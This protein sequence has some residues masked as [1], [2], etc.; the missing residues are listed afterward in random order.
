M[1]PAYDKQVVPFQIPTFV[2]QGRKH[3][4]HYIVDHALCLESGQ[5]TSRHGPNGG[6]GNTV[7]GRGWAAAGGAV[8]QGGAEVAASAAAAAGVWGCGHAAE[9]GGR[10]MAVAAAEGGASEGVRESSSAAAGAAAAALAG[11]AVA[12]PVPLSQHQ[13]AESSRRKRMTKKL[14]DDVR[15]WCGCAIM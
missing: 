6:G 9:S 14:S 15:G 1:F 10:S 4:G 11:Q 13:R 2:C 8:P 7:S 5:L 3:G 12:G